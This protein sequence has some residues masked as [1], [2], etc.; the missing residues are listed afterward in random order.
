KA[1]WAYLSTNS[2]NLPDWGQAANTALEVILPKILLFLFLL[3]LERMIP[4]ARSYGFDI[5]L[6]RCKM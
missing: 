3:D 5:H 6:S 2:T 4:L 1:H